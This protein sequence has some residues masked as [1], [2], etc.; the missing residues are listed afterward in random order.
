MFI[1]HN[2]P[3]PLAIGPTRTSL[4][5]SISNTPA[6]VAT[7]IY[8]P[9]SSLLISLKISA[10]SFLWLLP[11]GSAAPCLF[12]LM[13]GRGSPAALQFN[14]QVSPVAANTFTRGL[15]VNAGR[16]TTTSWVF[17]W[18]FP[19]RFA[20]EQKYVSE[21]LLRTSEICKTLLLYCALP[22]GK[23]WPVNFLQVTIGAG[24]PVT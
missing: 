10:P 24:Y 22:W 19:K 16:E 23:N 1:A 2:L 9:V 7:Q 20:A 14:V 13:T 15:T 6:L 21:S 18:T 11:T 17:L 3:V 5:A 8:I 12:Q 4:I